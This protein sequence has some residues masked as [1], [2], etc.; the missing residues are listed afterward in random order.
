[1]Q[2]TT[3]RITW[4]NGFRLNGQPAH[5]S[6]IREAF[7]KRVSAQ[8]WERYEQYKAELRTQNLTSA[9]YQSA[10]FEFAYML[11]I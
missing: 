2:T 7:D 11:G 9:E 8:K 6:D 3:D 4:R 1:M 10:L 5:I